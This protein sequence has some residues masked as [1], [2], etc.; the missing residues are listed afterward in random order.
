MG[1]TMN[2]EGRGINES[3]G[4]IRAGI[5]LRAQAYACGR[6]PFTPRPATMLRAGLSCSV[7]ITCALLLCGT[8][9]SASA[10]TDDA[11]QGT[12]TGRV[13]DE[14]GQP[15]ADARISVYSP[16]R[17]SNITSDTDGQFTTDKLPRST[18]N[19]NVFAPSYFDPANLAADPAERTYYQPGDTV[20]IRLHKGGIITGRVTNAAG[21]PLVA[22]RVAAIRVRPLAGQA[23]RTAA[24]NLRPF[25]R[26]T[27]DRGIY[28][29]YG[30]L[31]GVY[32]V[33]AGGQGAAGFSL[34]PSPYDDDAPTFYP[35]TTRDGATEVSV[36]AG[37][38]ATDIDIHYRG[39]PG[40][41]VSG[42]IGNTG[43]VAANSSI[44]VS[45]VSVGLNYPIGSR[46]LSGRDNDQS[47]VFTGI[48]D[49]DY[50][51]VAEQFSREGRSTAGSQRVRVRGQDVTGLKLT[52][53]PLA[54]VAGRVL[55]DAAPPT[56]A[57]PEQC[58]RKLNSSVSETTI[59]ARRERDQ[60]ADAALN[61][62]GGKLADT[63]P[64]DK[65]EFAL[66]GL[67]P[68]RFRLDVR[69][70]GPDWYIRTATLAP[71]PAPAAPN[72][73]RA[74]P[75][76]PTAAAANNSNPLV[77]GLTLAAGTQVSGL[78]LTLAPGA[79][80]LQGRV[81]P[82]G[83]GAGAALP[84]LQVYL[85]PAERERADDALRYVVA[86]VRADGTF[87]FSHLAPGRYHLIMRPIIARESGADEPLTMP[88][89]D[90]QTRAQLRRDIE[91]TET[92][93]LQPCQR[94]NDHVLRYAPKN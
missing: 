45:L 63:A 30:L 47:F 33:S 53:A 70:P 49:G 68:G 94:L 58:Q 82:A 64:D 77:D 52:L 81:A 31:P 29:I 51:L 85:V 19:V 55:L 92:I 54:A 73:K 69:P 22:V 48:A 7:L 61:P 39:E 13:I 57:W 12:I 35:A 91:T 74:P 37:Q 21:E 34:R 76:A 72:N 71:A 93:A 32:L 87:A 1:K 3:S 88:F 25:E 10:Q 36:Q 89:P 24:Q 42:A 50:D 75:S 86:H 16:R 60:G 84:D 62:G 23:A 11:A 27:D 90:A 14:A 41:A 44:S 46:F 38:E 17:Q 56:A 80:A 79:A 2:H 43:A 9:T 40:H 78:T 66:R 83:A 15:I 6:K 28:R 8:G 65:G 18:Y 67:A 59:I 5:M 4:S 26:V 20:T